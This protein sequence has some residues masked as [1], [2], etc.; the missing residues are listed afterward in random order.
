MSGLQQ[1]S[2]LWWQ[3][4][5]AEYGH[6]R[7]SASFPSLMEITVFTVT[8]VRAPHLGIKVSASSIRTPSSCGMHAGN[9]PGYEHCLLQPILHEQCLLHCYPQCS[10]RHRL[11]C[12]TFT[13]ICPQPSRHLGSVGVAVT[14][15]STSPPAPLH[16]DV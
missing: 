5:A 2:V 7:P 3:I 12:R 9:K 4:G 1:D 13:A 16:P 15:T 8:L 6:P 14:T 10:L 11:V